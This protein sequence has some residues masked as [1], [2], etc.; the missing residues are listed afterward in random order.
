[1][2]VKRRDEQVWKPIDVEGV[3]YCRLRRNQD[4][5]GGGATI[6]RMKKGVRYPAH[7]H[8]GCEDAYILSGRVLIDGHSLGPGDYWFTEPGEVHD[9]LAE[10]DLSF[11]VITEKAIRILEPQ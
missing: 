2:Y 8:P 4:E 1:M 3:E 7:A 5:G 11:L 9:A 10:E 6:V